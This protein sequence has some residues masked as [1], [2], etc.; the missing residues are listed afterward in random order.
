ML[1]DDEKGDMA[2][3]EVDSE[4]ACRV[5]RA[6]LIGRFLRVSL[7]ALFLTIIASAALLRFS[8][9]FLLFTILF[10]GFA[11]YLLVKSSRDYLRIKKCIVP[12]EVYERGVRLPIGSD[13][14]WTHYMPPRFISFKEVASFYPNEWKGLS[15]FVVTLKGK[16]ASEIVVEKML[17]GDWERFKKS[18][19]GKMDA[20]EGWVNL[21]SEGPVYIGN[22]ES[23]VKCLNLKASGTYREISW[24]SVSKYPPDIQ[25]RRLGNMALMRISLVDGTEL[26]I[27]LPLN[28]TRQVVNH[29]GTYLDSLEESEESAEKKQRLDI[30]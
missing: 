12:L 23:D 5:R 1:V 26:K 16:D 13:R 21:I 4:K 19:E 25:P 2:Y 3:S 10:G 28:T 20:R 24:D 7:C 30:L 27:L 8:I 18:V 22:V 17:I 11:L 9:G 15:Y 29:F 6:A 14:E